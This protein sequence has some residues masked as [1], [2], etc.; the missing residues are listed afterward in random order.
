MALNFAVVQPTLQVT[1]AL[2]IT[3]L[4]TFIRYDQPLLVQS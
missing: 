2:F 4:L 3:S 1:F